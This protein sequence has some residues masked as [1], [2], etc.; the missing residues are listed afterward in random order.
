MLT[1]FQEAATF[2]D[3]GK[4]N[5]RQYPPKPWSEVL[6]GAD[7]AAVDFVSSLV[8]YESTHRLA[9][10]QALEHPYLATA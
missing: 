5:F 2:P 7:L 4:M 1:K 3:W 8:V 9:A 10:R 6:E